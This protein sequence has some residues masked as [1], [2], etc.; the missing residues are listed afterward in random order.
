MNYLFNFFIFPGFI[1]TLVFGLLASWV[2][3]KITA[4]IQWRVGPPWYQG[5]MDLVK[6]S[7][8]EIIMPDT[9]SVM[10]L[11]APFIGLSAVMLAGHFVWTA[12]MTPASQ[13]FIG[14]IIV[15][16]YLL[17]LPSLAIILG[18]SASGNVLA[19]LGASRESKLILSYELPFIISLLVPVVKSKGLLKLQDIIAYQ[20]GNGAFLSDLSGILAFIVVIFCIQAKLGFVPFDMAEAET[21]IMGGVFIEYSGMLLAIFKI[22]KMILIVIL[23]VFIVS[24]FWAGFGIWKYLAVLT[25]LIL[26]KNVNPRVRIDQAMRFF[27]RRMA[28]LAV[29]AMLLAIKGM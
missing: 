28:L 18:A 15:I 24:M 12:N 5:V 6:L 11:I 29:L 17:T 8:K 4:R 13:G 22:T 9:A 20:A 25:I 19:S 27:W 1:F 7:L 3:R 10:F 21:E 23:P 14:D 2:D 16:I 26:I